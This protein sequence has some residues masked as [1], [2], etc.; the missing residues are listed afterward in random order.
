MNRCPW[1]VAFLRKLVGLDD[2]T[3]RVR[4]L[5]WA[6]DAME[7]ARRLGA[8]LEVIDRW[9]RWIA[10][11]VAADDHLESNPSWC[12][13]IAEQIEDVAVRP[14][15]PLHYHPV[16]L[17]DLAPRPG[18]LDRSF[19]SFGLSR[20]IEHLRRDACAVAARAALAALTTPADHDPG[21]EQE[22]L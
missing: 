8:P 3:R 19:P 10:E 5:R 20:R 1:V 21:D 17:Y 18:V 6:R 12:G 7:S 11:A 2:R 14:P 9:R 16:R 13:W 4:E 22:R 15:I